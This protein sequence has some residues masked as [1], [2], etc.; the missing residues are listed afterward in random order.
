MLQ[1]NLSSFLV[2]MHYEDDQKIQLTRQKTSKRIDAN[3]IMGNTRAMG[4]K[5]R[6]GIKRVKIRKSYKVEDFGQG[7]ER[8]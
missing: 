7:L 1:Y 3:Y 6:K 5:V 2:K 8:F 4:K